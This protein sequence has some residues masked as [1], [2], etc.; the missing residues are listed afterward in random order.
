MPVVPGHIGK[1]REGKHTYHYPSDQLP[2]PKLSI[3]RNQ[4]AMH[5]GTGRCTASLD[6]PGLSCHF[7][8]NS[9][10]PSGGPSALHHCVSCTIYLPSRRQPGILEILR[11]VAIS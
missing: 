11:R 4:V 6:T 2:N 1:P 9:S 5:Q 7:L 3:R 10:T 8:R